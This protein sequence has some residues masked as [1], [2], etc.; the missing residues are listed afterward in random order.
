MLG[1]HQ[2]PEVEDHQSVNTQLPT[3]EDGIGLLWNIRKLNVS[4]EDQV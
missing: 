2:R 1:H 3:A 4:V